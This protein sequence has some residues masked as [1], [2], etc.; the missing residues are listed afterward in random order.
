VFIYDSEYDS[1]ITNDSY[2]E[3][4]VRSAALSYLRSAAVFFM[5]LSALRDSGNRKD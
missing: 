5:H 2:S 4:G 3:L 1:D